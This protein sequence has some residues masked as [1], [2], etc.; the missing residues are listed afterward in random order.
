MI[1]FLA[2]YLV[3]VMFLGLGILWLIDGRVKKENVFHTLIAT[4]FVWA[5]CEMIKALFPV[6]RPFVTNGSLIKTATLPLSATFPSIHSAVAFSMAT[7]IYLHDK[8][9][10]TVFI[11]AAIGVALGRVWANVHYP[12]DVLAGAVLGVVVS[13]G[14]EKFHVFKLIKKLS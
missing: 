8:K 10:G 14:L 5:A 3:W 1:T 4:M 6:A 11:L 13:I 12:V 9:L 7:M 2:S